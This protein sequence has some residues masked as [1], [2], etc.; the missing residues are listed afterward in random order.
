MKEFK[1]LIILG[2][3]IY[4]IH[5]YEE[6]VIFNFREWRLRYFLDNNAIATEEV[7]IRLISILLIVV[8]IHFL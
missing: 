4:A 5:H 7:L 3:L 8:F 6:H 2:P 1:N